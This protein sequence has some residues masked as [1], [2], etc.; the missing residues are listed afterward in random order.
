[1]HQLITT[2]T[3]YDCGELMEGRVA[4][5]KYVESGLSTVVLKNILVFRCS[6]CGG[7]MP[8]IGAAAQLHTWIAMHLLTKKTR[9]TGEEIRFL[10]KAVGYSATHLA[11]MVGTSKSIV[12]RWENHSTTSQQNDRLV[13]LIC[14]NKMLSDCLLGSVPSDISEH[15]VKQAQELLAS[16]DDTL[17]NFRKTKSAK[18]QRFTIDPAELSRLGSNLVN[19]SPRPPVAVQ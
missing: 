1:M 12:S 9:L 3:C 13:R 2:S 6:H 10:R 8:Q 19:D 18:N 14:L 7:V 15:F 16:M 4:D 5:Y 11:K 17:K